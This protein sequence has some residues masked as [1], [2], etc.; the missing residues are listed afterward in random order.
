MDKINSP[1]D[2]NYVAKKTKETTKPKIMDDE[3][4]MTIEDYKRISD[5]LG[6]W[7]WVPCT[8]RPEEIED[9]FQN[10]GYKITKL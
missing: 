2:L 4:K 1:Y 8:P 3:K 10:L 9:V 6:L 5:E 7:Q